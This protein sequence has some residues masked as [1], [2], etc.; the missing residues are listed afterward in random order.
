MLENASDAE[1]TD[2]DLATLCH[3]NVLGFQVAMEDFTIV[4]MLDRQRHLN[5]PIENLV[6]RVTD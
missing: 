2:L 1:V 3:E 4:Y 5:K 6:L